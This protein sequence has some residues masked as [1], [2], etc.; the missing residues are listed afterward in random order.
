MSA[1]LVGI[2]IG[3]RQFFRLIPGDRLQ[4][5]LVVHDL[6]DV[7]GR[8]LI[9]THLT[10][11]HDGATVGEMGLTGV[12]TGGKH[13]Q[14][15]VRLDVHIVVI[16]PR[17]HTDFLNVLHKISSRGEAVPHIVEAAGIFVI[18]DK[19]G[20]HLVI[21]LMVDGVHRQ[22]R[23][24]T[25]HTDVHQQLV[26][27]GEHLTA[28]HIVAVDDGGLIVAL[29]CDAVAAVKEQ[30][31]VLVFAAVEI[32]IQILIVV[33][34]LHDGVVDAVPLLAGGGVGDP[35][36]N[37]G[38]AV[39]QR[40]ERR[41]HPFGILVEFLHLG[42]EFLVHFGIVQASEVFRQLFVLDRHQPQIVEQPTE[43]HQNTDDAED[44]DRFPYDGDDVITAHRDE[45]IH[46][47]LAE[48]PLC[49]GGM[50][51]LAIF[52]LVRFNAIL[53]R[54]G[55]LS[56]GIDGGVP[57]GFRRCDDGRLRL[58][59]FLEEHQRFVFAFGSSLRLL[60][61][62]FLFQQ[63]EGIIVVLVFGTACKESHKEVLL[64]VYES[65]CWRRFARRRADRQRPR[66]CCVSQS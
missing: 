44:G 2:I 24:G 59:L 16:V 50:L 3:E 39:I 62:L 32:A 52:R 51:R 55:R 18:P 1:L 26:E 64:I 8:R 53:F 43:R 29:R 61:L 66:L 17:T 57:I 63:E 49:R 42:G 33:A 10:G 46:Q 40:T 22:R 38:V 36:A 56:K 58:R 30:S 28:E 19:D 54:F 5:V 12:A 11:D 25:R 48:S 41:I 9:R 13:Q 6:V 7:D 21:G 34:C 27:G 60:R 20:K 15:V 65:A 35:A 31:T 45:D 4:H 47:Q 23:S 37:V 14:L